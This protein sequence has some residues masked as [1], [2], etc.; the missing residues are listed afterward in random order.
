[1]S[2]EPCTHINISPNLR[3]M[4]GIDMDGWPRKGGCGHENADFAR[5][6]DGVVLHGYICRPDHVGNLIARRIRVPV[7]TKALWGFD[8][9]SRHRLISNSLIA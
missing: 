8:S 2:Q 5:A 3:V 6:V 1:M 9:P 4:F 7:A